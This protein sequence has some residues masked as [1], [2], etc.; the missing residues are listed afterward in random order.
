MN[1]CD[2][3]TAPAASPS[4]PGRISL[5]VVLSLTLIHFTG[6][7]Y[8]SFV[9]PLLPVLAERFTLSMTQVGLITAVNRLLAFVIQPA[10]GYFAD[11]HQTRLFILGGPLLSAA[12]IPLI[13]IAP[14]YGVLLLCISLGSVGSAM[15][16]PTC[17]GMV[18]AYAGRHLGL[19]L[20]L[21]TLGGTL[22]FAVGPI[23]I[24]TYVNAFG[25]QALPLTLLLGV[26]PMVYLFRVVPRPE[27]EGL[28]EHGFLRSLQEA[29]GGVWRP[30]TLLWLVMLIRSYV[31]QSFL[32]Y[33]PLYLSRQGQDLVSVGLV[34]SLFTV[35][36]ALSGILG[37]HLSDRSGY[38]TV[39]CISHALAVPSLYLLLRLKGFWILPGAFLAGF[40]ILA[41]LP[42]G[43]AMAQ[44][45]AP[46]GRSMV[47]SLMMGLALGGGGMLAPVTGK[48]ADLYSIHTALSGVAMLP[49][50]TL[51]LIG[52][53]AHNR[54]PAPLINR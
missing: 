1:P 20:S 35:A 50:L 37:G 49:L 15:F 46:K 36:G 22:A 29:F 28:R 11:R 34:V 43:L 32:T 23:F 17:A 21:F 42:L 18:P 24:A 19:A 10:S 38:R 9:H 45:L 6:D 27:A 52:F 47:S 25:L 39:F 5:K 14:T 26:P 3:P 16:H 48:L 54:K 30:V 12:F 7:L 53:I 33:V 2:S 40:F 8:A 44:E 41:T 4:A 13:G 31:S 51:P